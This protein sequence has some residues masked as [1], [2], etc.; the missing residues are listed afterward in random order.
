MN[1]VNNGFRSN[2]LKGMIDVSNMQAQI[3]DELFAEF[4]VDWHNDLFARRT[5]CGHIDSWFGFVDRPV[6]DFLDEINFLV[7][8]IREHFFDFQYVPSNVR[9]GDKRS[10]LLGGYKCFS[11]GFGESGAVGLLEEF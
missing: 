11:T 1:K 5:F 4:R 6:N 8:K 2:F 9:Q 3:F 7:R 10:H